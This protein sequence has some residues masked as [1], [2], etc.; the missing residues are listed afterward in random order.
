MVIGHFIGAIEYKNL[1][2]CYF[3]VWILECDQNNC[4]VVYS[5][6]LAVKCRVDH[7]VADVVAPDVL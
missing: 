1:I 7:V 3:V 2:G 5:F 6:S 4:S